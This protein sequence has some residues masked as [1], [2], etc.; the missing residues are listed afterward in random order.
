M[1]NRNEYTSVYISLYLLKPFKCNTTLLNICYL[2]N[3][4]KVSYLISQNLFATLPADT[5]KLDDK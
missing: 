2:R 5:Y 4:I 3:K 1:S